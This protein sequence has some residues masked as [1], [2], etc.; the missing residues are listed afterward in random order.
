MPQRSPHVRV[1]R[2]VKKTAAK[3]KRGRTGRPH[4]IR[5][6]IVGVIIMT[7]QRVRCAVCLLL[8]KNRQRSSTRAEGPMQRC[9]RWLSLAAG[10]SN[11]ACLRARTQELPERCVSV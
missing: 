1:D 10:R 3:Q 4:Y 2:P 9:L 5:Q 11:G 7:Q 6:V 8:R